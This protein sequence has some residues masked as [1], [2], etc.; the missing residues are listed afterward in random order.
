M[1]PMLYFNNPGMISTISAACSTDISNLIPDTSDGSVLS[2]VYHA[3]LADTALI[4]VGY[5]A[6]TVETRRVPQRLGN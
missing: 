6:P 3:T 4:G 1:A 2:F 5:M